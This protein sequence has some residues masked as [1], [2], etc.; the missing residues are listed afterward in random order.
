MADT[1]EEADPE[2]LAAG[3]EAAL[4][5]AET[6]CAEDLGPILRMELDEP[7]S[8]DLADMKPLRA[9]R[10]RRL[11]EAHHLTIRSI[12]DVLLHPHPPVDFLILFKQ[13]LKAHRHD[14]ASDK[15]PEVAWVLYLACIVA[16]ML[17]CQRQITMLTPEALRGHLRWALA[18]TWIDPRLAALLR[19]GL[20]HLE[21]PAAS[22]PHGEAPIPGRP[23][24]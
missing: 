12:A 9:E 11:C 5:D 2:Q 6:W 23:P 17:R 7:L 1:F 14:P 13:Y 22:S 4:G 20:E 3:L 24:T 10:L 21:K 18:Q 16:A 8:V 19:E 15:P